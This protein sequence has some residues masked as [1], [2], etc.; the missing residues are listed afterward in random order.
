[1]RRS[2][3][4]CL[5]AL[6]GLLWGADEGRNVAEAQDGKVRGSAVDFRLNPEVLVIYEEGQAEEARQRAEAA[7]YEVLEDYEPG[8]FLRCVP[9]EG[10]AI[11][12]ALFNVPQ[13]AASDAVQVIEPNYIVS[14][15][16]PPGE[17]P[18]VQ[19]ADRGFRRGGKPEAQAATP[20][21]PRF[22][23]LW[24]MSNIHAPV[25]WGAVH[26]TPVVVG[27]ID[28]GVDYEHEDLADNM[29]KNPGESGDGKETNG[30]DDD[31]NGIADDVFG[32]K[33]ENGVGSGDPMDDN[34]H[35]THCAGTIGA[36][37]NNGKGVVGV[38]W[39]VQIMALKFLTASGSGTTNDA[40]RCIDYAI[41]QKENGV[42]LKVL[43]NSWG[44]GGRS[45]ALADA[46]TRA[47]QAGILFV[48]AA[49]NDGEDN[50]EFSN[51]PSNY[52][53]ENVLA[54]AAINPSDGLAPFSNF[55]ATTV[56]I[57]APGV[58]ILSTVPDNGYEEFNGTS[59][60][61]PHVAGAAALALN[62]PEHRNKSAVE[63]KGLL[64]SKARPLSSLLGKC[65]SG[66][67][68]DIQF[69]GTPTT[70][71]P[72]PGLQGIAFN[73][74]QGGQGGTFVLNGQ[75]GE[76]L[77]CLG[78]TFYRT[79]LEFQGEETTPDNFPGSVYREDFPNS[80]FDFLFT[81]ST[82][83]SVPYHRVYVRPAGDSNSPFTWFIDAMRCEAPA[84]SDASSSRMRGLD[85][86]RSRSEAMGRG[87]QGG[88]GAAPRQE[89]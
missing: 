45:Q 34:E 82:I 63:I 30:E 8:H 7:G 14:I 21:D 31:G 36:V 19:A 50:D 4:A 57:G 23:E 61:T 58:D 54:V 17:Q 84:S 88:G 79:S 48:A 5:P 37:G 41:A 22:S 71:E 75:N 10:V 12:R 47:E 73:G 86:L 85:A 25:A 35:G 55:G 70:P 13:I 24:G 83:G 51:F 59:M 67:T 9:Q 42:N 77:Y 27:V 52:P 81:E 62:H 53:N 43:S 18:E 49:S 16:R 69:L 1:M 44:G 78:S 32:A 38:N 87:A 46:I 29:W 64:M 33:F 76:A 15:P 89:R 20:D 68:L 74:E 3:V 40:I 60:A 28:T 2:L 66:A 11:A 26:E 39:T 56:D 72:G 80:P 65:V 6:V